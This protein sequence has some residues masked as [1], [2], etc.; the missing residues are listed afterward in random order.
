[1]ID[2]NRGSKSGFWQSFWG[3]LVINICIT[4][5]LGY[6][7]WYYFGTIRTVYNLKAGTIDNSRQYAQDFLS[8][9]G[10]IFTVLGY[11]LTIFQVWKLR[12]EQE[13]VDDT[14]KEVT[15]KLFRATT[16]ESIG[17]AKNIL[18]EL[19]NKIERASSFTEEIVREYI[20]RLEEVKE[21]LTNIDASKKALDDSELCE[22]CQSLAGKCITSFSD[23]IKEKKFD[24]LDKVANKGRINL[25]IQ[26]LIKINP[27][28]TN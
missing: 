21:I 2:I 14:R 20:D 1:M 28:I 6:T 19:H 7:F 18:K 11:V 26:E 5:I 13:T 4:V 8:V 24:Q 3:L 23:T 16:S 12:T 17:K 27:Q 22:N 9:F 15:N 10:S 25:L